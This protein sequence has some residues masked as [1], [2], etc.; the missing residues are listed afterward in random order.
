MRCV[1]SEI[2]IPRLLL[3]LLI[4]THNPPKWMSP[5]K[6]SR[7]FWALRA[8][9]GISNFPLFILRASSSIVSPFPPPNCGDI[10]SSLSSHKQQLRNEGRETDYATNPTSLSTSN[11][12]WLQN[13]HRGGVWKL[14]GVRFLKGFRRKKTIGFCPSCAL[15]L[16]SFR[17]WSRCCNVVWPTR[18]L[19]K[20]RFNRCLAAVWKICLVIFLFSQKK[21]LAFAVVQF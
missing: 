20:A 21:R 12:L 6:S 8:P 18:F 16:T 14:W 2:F 9:W 7:K 17:V 19:L 10:A 15:L 1:P 4:P 13:G 11:G 3:Q 5:T